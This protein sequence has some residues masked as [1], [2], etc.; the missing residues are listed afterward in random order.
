MVAFCRQKNWLNSHFFSK[1]IDAESQWVDKLNVTV[2]WDW[3]KSSHHRW[4]GC[5]NHVVATLFVPV[6]IGCLEL[7]V[8]LG[9]VWRKS[10]MIWIGRTV[11]VPRKKKG[12][13]NQRIWLQF[14]KRPSR[15]AVPVAIRCLELTVD[16]GVGSIPDSLG[17]FESRTESDS[18]CLS[19]SWLELSGLAGSNGADRFDRFDPWFHFRTN[20]LILNTIIII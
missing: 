5:D 19:K 3:H 9:V 1:K 12:R 20:L 8:D 4:P 15:R 14:F 10:Q 16:L 11:P 17:R 18:D 6:A 2:Y 7:T 13:D